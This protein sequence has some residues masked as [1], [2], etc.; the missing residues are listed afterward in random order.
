MRATTDAP[1]PLGHDASTAERAEAQER[2][3]AIVQDS[4]NIRTLCIGCGADTLLLESACCA[5][6][7]FVCAA[8]QRI[9]DE[10]VCEHER[11]EGIPAE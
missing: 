10:G 1:Q 4:A 5:C 6:G 11:P 8:C 2:F 9:E 3:Q 7:G